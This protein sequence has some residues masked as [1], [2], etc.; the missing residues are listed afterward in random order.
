MHFRILLIL[1]SAS[2]S[3]T[4][5]HN[6]YI[7]IQS[8]NAQNFYIRKGAEITSS[9]SSGFVILPR[10]IPGQQ[11]FVIGFP[12]NEF[13]EYQFAIEIKGKDRGFALKNFN[14][15]GWGL[16]DLQSLEVIMGRKVE[17]K[18]EQEKADTGPLTSDP[19][20][21]ILASAVGDQ[22]IRQTS[23]VYHE[24]I[25]AQNTAPAKTETINNK[26]QGV[27]KTEAAVA[28][29]SA[30]AKKEPVITNPATTNPAVSNA[31][32]PALESAAL[33]AVEPSKNEETTRK[34][35]K[36]D[37]AAN[38]D[39]SLVKPETI[40]SAAVVTDKKETAA[41]TTVVPGKKEKP[42]EHS[43]E[44]LQTEPTRIKSEP[45]NETGNAK[46]TG[47]FKKNPFARKT[48]EPV[49]SEPGVVM[50]SGGPDKET[51]VEKKG[52][53]A[54]KETDLATGST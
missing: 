41:N 46:K 22:R 39:S 36:V 44:P 21:V 51:T 19:F 48:P 28:K 2:L 5:Q 30:P 6:H 11:E 35:E 43:G 50:I 10:I 40:A 49:K 42:S 45:V 27:S 54:V 13:P 1:I 53:E 4:A 47:L 8:D 3:V 18:K 24:D 38:R 33:G 32:D 7:Y 31:K 34:T 12:K 52:K 20:S 37:S 9:S 17:V 14:E 26:S 29:T 25:I 23:L 15:K 16:F